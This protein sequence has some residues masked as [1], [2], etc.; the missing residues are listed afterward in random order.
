MPKKIIVVDLDG[1]LLSTNTFHKWIIFLFRKSLYI[2]PFHSIQILFILAQRLL[3]QITHKE[4]KYKI[5]KISQKENYT[6]YIASFIESLNKYL[7]Q[8]VLSHVQEE[9]SLTILATAAPALYAN[10]I[11]SK[12]NID[13]CSATPSIF[14][15]IWYENIK[16]KKKENLQELLDHLNLKDI[17]IVISDHH[18]DLWIMEMATRVILVNPSEKTKNILQKTNIIQK[19]Y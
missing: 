12:Y 18:D 13:Y 15:N 14:S 2:N 11:A 5:L 10:A 9:N 6:Y 7:N 4:M 19:L 8:D 16:E 17:A 3:K 1:T